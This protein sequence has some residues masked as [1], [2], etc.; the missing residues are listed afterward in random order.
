MRRLV[1]VATVLA[2]FAA[3][4]L[5]QPASAASPLLG[6]WSLDGSQVVAGQDV[7]PDASG[8]G[9]PLRTASGAMR[10]D[11]AGGR[12]AGG[13][14]ATSTAPL[15]SDPAP[16][17]PAQVTLLAWIKQSGNPGNLKYIA[18]RGYDGFPT[19]SGS[20]FA[21]Y[22]AYA[23]APGLRF[24]VR[25]PDPTHPGT[26][27]SALSDAPPNASVFDGNWH[28]I[29]GTFDG[30]TIRFYVDGV[31]IGAPKTMPAG[32]G[33]ALPGSP[34]GTNMYVGA[35]P[36]SACDTGGQSSDFPGLIDEVRVYDRAL[37]RTELERLAEPFAT[38][39]PVLEP[40]TQP[41]P[42]PAPSET[43]AP[44]EAPA[45]T[46]APAPT[47]EFAPVA[48]ADTLPG[49]AELD[50]SASQHVEQF[51]W[52]VGGDGRTD[53]T[54]PGSQPV[55]SVSTAVG[56][57][58][59]V[60]LTT[61]GAGG[62]QSVRLP[63]STLIKPTIGIS[64][65]RKAQQLQRLP[66]ALTRIT[67]DIA[68]CS[69]TR[70]SATAITGAHNV[71]IVDRLCI[72]QTVIW[73]LASASGCFVQAKDEAEVPPA[74]RAVIRS[75]YE[76]EK[77]PPT[78]LV[79]CN[80]AA[81]APNDA[82]AQQL[83]AR[84]K[85]I[86]TVPYDVY[87]AKGGAVVDLNGLKITPKPGASIVVF[88]RLGRIVTSNATMTWGKMT[89]RTGALDFNFRNASRFKFSCGNTKDCVHGRSEAIARYDARKDLP[90]IA[91][92]SVNGFVDLALEAVDGERTSSGIM[93]LTLP[94]DF[95]VWGSNPPSA[96]VKVLGRTGTGPVLDALR[97][98]VPEASLGPLRMTDVQ[99]Q[100]AA[101]GRINGDTDPNSTCDRNEWRAQANVFIA[102]GKGGEAGFK[103]SPPP[104]Q[105][106]VGFCDG[107]FRHAGGK[108]IFGGPIPRP[109]LF[110]GVFLNNI[111]FAMQ[112][113]PFLARGGVG[114]DV[115]DIARVDGALLMALAT[116]QEPYTLTPFDAGGEFAQLAG[117]KFTSTTIMGGGNVSLNFPGVGYI[118]V[119]SAA[120]MWSYPDHVAASG[121]VRIVVPGFAIYG[122]A[123][124]EALFGSAQFTS[125]IGGKACLAG[126]KKGLCIG[127]DG[128]VTSKGIVACLNVLDTLHPG[129]GLN[130][131]TR[132]IEIWPIDGCKPS[133][134]WITF[135]AA[136]AARA[137]RLG[138]NDARTFTVE[139]G[140]DVKNVRIL[141]P[142]D[143]PPKVKVT[144]PGGEVLTI[145]G[146]DWVRSAHM[147][148]VRFDDNKAVY[149]G[150]KDGPAGTYTVEALDGSS[151][152]GEMAVTRDEF[153]SDV[154]A[155]VGA[156]GARA[157]RAVAA[158]EP[159]AA[160]AAALV[161]RGERIL[162]YDTGRKG[163]N[164]S[165]RFVEQSGGQVLQ[166]IA[167]VGAGKGT[168]RFTPAAGPSG[169]RDIVAE[170]TV[171]GVPA[172]PQI[173][174]SYTFGGERRLPAPSGI[175]LRRRGS[176][177]VV[178]WRPVV[179]ADRYGLLL[180]L[181]SGAERQLTATGRQ[182]RLTI[183]HVPL[184]ESATVRLTAR[185]GSDVA[186]GRSRT[187]RRI[188][189]TKRL[190]TVLQ[191]KTT[192][193]KKGNF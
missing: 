10:L 71:A 124:V 46:P 78:V 128:W 25:G 8:E 145:D 56:A 165:V 174:A 171:D 178:S 96:E 189:A 105:N 106:G 135:R 114:I 150:V 16:L 36:T 30:T 47:A 110:P 73:G 160:R 134:Y 24:Y 120:A 126:V 89:V 19:C 119:G 104:S 111:N 100:Y 164:L 53:V 64:G 141:S 133:H 11:L 170:T 144:A 142:G 68:V 70:I 95:G 13:L 4:A 173:I 67:P 50:A 3:A 97:L 90:S 14:G 182:R 139:R 167:T 183:T 49:R 131:S 27:T 113:H 176:S 55:L 188:P 155:K 2:V 31:Q 61:I 149:L 48:T 162:R 81:A 158:R 66:F 138:A 154:S 28:L 39:P 101:R 129:A 65:I 181:G 69:P 72:R 161:T 156:S 54:C 109:Q 82:D 184:T 146:D 147:G 21:L 35:Y 98:T 42:A 32:I 77:Y 76:S 192:N 186:W 127:G 132:R 20:S 26:Y 40:G 74:E 148:G 51:N 87:V 115:A 93:Q 85:E 136:R 43:P 63:S 117:R 7:T 108:I 99:F 177:L 140:E 91:G 88:P 168:L 187:S 57:T 152:L 80:R 163:G 172:A 45:P 60:A 102:G 5:A 22:T 37:S 175:T 193:E 41:T 122:H 59:P 17:A 116:P 38:T 121:E 29:A 191:T 84:A 118:P 169:K 166:T 15:L 125:S 33:Y 62:A 12:F 103:L 92:F 86:M 130:W 180:R 179:G 6:Q 58:K 137:A 44:T 157:V 9:H 1:H 34:G 159:V 151:P 94:P 79:L 83:C 52:D 185:A 190:P 18:G 123:G 143:A 23:A 107:G 112:L 153:D 75:H